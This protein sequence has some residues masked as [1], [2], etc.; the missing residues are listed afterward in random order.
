MIHCSLHPVLAGVAP[1]LRAQSVEIS[2]D[3]DS[4]SRVRYAADTI[5]VHTLYQ[6]RYSG[7]VPIHYITYC[8]IEAYV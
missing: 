2:T 6:D 8:K 3:Q 1:R 4:S 5:F 7:E